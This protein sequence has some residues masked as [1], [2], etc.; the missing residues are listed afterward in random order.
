M[1]LNVSRSTRILYF[2][3]PVIPFCHLISL[4]N[5][6]DPRKQYIPICAHRRFDCL[7]FRVVIDESARHLIQSSQVRRRLISGD[8]SRL[9]RVDDHLPRRIRSAYDILVRIVELLDERFHVRVER[10]REIS[11]LSLLIVGQIQLPEEKSQMLAKI[12]SIEPRHT[13][14]RRIPR[15]EGPTPLKKL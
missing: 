14:E 15:P 1:N 13:S 8:R 12:K 11:D 3:D 10:F 4:K 6:L 9:Q 2:R 7:R 5:R